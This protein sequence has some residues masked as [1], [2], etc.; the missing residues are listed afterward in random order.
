MLVVCLH[1]GANLKTGLHVFVMVL[2]ELGWGLL[3]CFPVRRNL[4]IQNMWTVM[5]T[6]EQ[7]LQPLVL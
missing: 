5:G 4:L 1:P 2:L 3:L 6:L 7:V